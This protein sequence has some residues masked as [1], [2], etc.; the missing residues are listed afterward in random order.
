MKQQS[1]TVKKQTLYIAVAAAL[2]IGF[3]GGVMYSAFQTPSTTTT[4]A[5]DREHNHDGRQEVIDALIKQTNEQ[6]DNGE[7]WTQLGH[8]YFDSDRYGEAIQAYEKALTIRPGD[9]NVM[10]DL[11]VMYRRNNDPQKAVDTFD[12]VLQRDPRHQQA[13]FNKGVVLL[14]DFNDKEAAVAEWKKLVAMNPMA[15]APSGTPLSEIIEQIEK[16]NTQ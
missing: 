9:T 3:L 11:G 8:A 10:T 15:K 13:R 1:D 6:P 7:A 4:A 14:N 16:S 5:T 2:L 12:K